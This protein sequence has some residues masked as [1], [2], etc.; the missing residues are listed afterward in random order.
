M[1]TSTTVTSKP[2]AGTIADEILHD[3][4]TAGII[5][6]GFFVKNPNSQQKAQTLIQ[7]VTQDL[8]PMLDTQLTS[9]STSASTTTGTTSTVATT[10][11]TAPTG[12]GL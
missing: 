8:L 1:S 12:A 10:S 9:T 5:A 3:V 2:S 4:I 6:A 11:T 7:L